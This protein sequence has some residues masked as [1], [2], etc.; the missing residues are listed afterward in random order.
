MIRHHE[1]THTSLRSTLQSFALHGIAST[2][3]IALVATWAGCGGSISTSQK[4]GDQPDSG[5]GTSGNDG[6]GAPGMTG[7][8]AA[9]AG[10]AASAADANGAPSDTYPAFA[11]DVAQVIDNGGPVLTAPVVVTI[12]WST[13]TGADTYNAFGD[14]I[15]ASAYWKDINSEY[16]VGPAVSGAANHI[17]ITTAPP[18]TYS[19]AQLDA[20]VES[21]AGTTWPAYTTNT[22]Y[23]VYLP[24]GTDL[25][26]GGQDACS[27]GIGGYHT[28]SQNKN[29]VYAIM[30]HCNG[31]QTSD[32]E[33]DASHE[34]NEASTDP[35]PSTAT[36]Y[37][38]F[39]TN[40]LAFEFFNSFQDELGDACEAFVTASDA[41]D[42][43]P[44]TVQRQW[45]NKSAAAGSQWCL[46]KLPEPM[47]NT[48][49]LPSTN[50]DTITVNLD[51]LY[52]GAGTTTSKGFKM[53][54]NTSRTFPIGLFSDEATSGPFALDVYGMTDPIAQDQNGNNINN[55]TATVS[56]DLSSGVNGQIANVTVTPTAYSSLGITFFSIRSQLMGS[57]Q[58]HYLPVLISQN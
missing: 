31:F 53:A 13:D 10:D 50:L 32:I 44:Y 35:H 1:R 51:A 5:T 39:D 26:L 52:P 11:I 43:T 9:T 2:L 49:F 25:T 7:N 27:Q 14:S 41:V 12:T 22:I 8:D 56:F 23:A 28:E 18:T 54:L 20:L 3:S 4:S 46:P 19:D 36:A 21:S 48:T 38:G 15:G 30:P 55:G 17:S 40:H 34:L 24:L 45:S 6:G 57:Q 47:Y 42:F 16:G 29:Y 37:M 33:L 58:H